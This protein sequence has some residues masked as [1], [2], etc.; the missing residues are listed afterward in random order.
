MD[1]LGQIAFNS[2]EQGFCLMERIVCQKRARVDYY[3]QY[4]NTAFTHLTTLE[5]VIGKSIRQVM[6]RKAQRFVEYC[7]QVYNS[8]RSLDLEIHVELAGRCLA[9][10]MFPTQQNDVI[11]VIF[12]YTGPYKKYL[13]PPGKSIEEKLK[14]ETFRQTSNAREEERRRISESLH[15][16]LGQLLYAAKL[17]LRNLDLSLE[18][19]SHQ[20]MQARKATEKLISEAILECRRISHELAPVFLE[21]HGLMAAIDDVRR[22]LFDGLKAK[23]VYRNLEKPMSR[24]LELAVFRT[25][26]E[27]MLNVAKHAQARNCKVEIERLESGVHIHVE[28]DVIGF[29]TTNEAK[30]CIG[31]SNIKRTTRLLEGRFKIESSIN[32]GTSIDVFVP[33]VPDH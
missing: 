8:G 25:V 24:Y 6:G 11:G 2:N 15:N 14:L 1:N 7:D 23:C 30:M 12:T 9:V 17:S 21:E 20:Y 32:S 22:H 16:G 31:L 27:L 13:E 18:I 10:Q 29:D 33:D 4:A 26:Q 3:Y 5:N 28:D 19:G